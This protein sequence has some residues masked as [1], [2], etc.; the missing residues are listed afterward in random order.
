MYAWRETY[1]WSTWKCIVINYLTLNIE[2]K[3]LSSSHP[4]SPT[5][6]L[7]TLIP[8]EQPAWA[9]LHDERLKAEEED[10]CP[11]VAY[12]YNMRT[13]ASTDACMH[14]FHLAIPYTSNLNQHIVYEKTRKPLW[15]GVHSTGKQ[16]ILDTNPEIFLVI[17]SWP[18]GIDL[19]IPNSVVAVK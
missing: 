9:R 11:S 1:V 15:S 13:I 12:T 14:Q 6:K 18:M 10:C 4:L 3:S 8:L 16:D 7:H 2:T 17:L 19:R 5:F